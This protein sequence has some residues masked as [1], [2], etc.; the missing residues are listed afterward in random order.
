MDVRESLANAGH[1]LLNERS[2]CL[3]GQAR[4]AG[5]PEPA[6]RTSVSTRGLSRLICHAQ[7][8]ESS[9]LSLA[10]GSM[11]I[12]PL[13]HQLLMVKSEHVMPK[14]LV[15]RDSGKVLRIA[16]ADRRNCHCTALPGD[17]RDKCIPAFPLA[18]RRAR[19]IKVC[20]LQMGD[21][22]VQYRLTALPAAPVQ[23]QGASGR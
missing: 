8:L 10:Q 13:L 14:R 17:E 7:C 15:L 5:R 21:V 19:C 16:S 2:P 3:F 6:Q 18:N 4:R 23:R 22:P 1:A 11:L 20:R 9:F 12:H